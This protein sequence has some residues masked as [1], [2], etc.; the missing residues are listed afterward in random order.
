MFS[1]FQD[2]QDFEIFKISRYIQRF[3][4]AIPMMEHRNQKMVVGV[5]LIYFT[6]A[7]FVVIHDKSWKKAE[8]LKK[9]LKDMGSYTTET[10]NLLESREDTV[11]I[12]VPDNHQTN[13]SPKGGHPRAFYVYEARLKKYYNFAK[14]KVPDFLPKHFKARIEKDLILLSRV[15]ME[16]RKHDKKRILNV[17]DGAGKNEVVRVRCRSGVGDPGQTQRAPKRLHRVFLR[18]YR[19]LRKISSSL[20]MTRFPNAD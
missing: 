11:E 19:H 9:L 1:R 13:W 6:L 8:Q 12:C 7:R 17:G 15:A 10:I 16:M 5:F 3:K 20:L 2:F 14:F 18:L 4:I